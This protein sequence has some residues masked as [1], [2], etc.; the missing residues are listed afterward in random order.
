[1]FADVDSR[2]DRFISDVPLEVDEDWH[3]DEQLV[4]SVEGVPAADLLEQ[5]AREDHP[6]C[7]EEEGWTGLEQYP[8]DDA[9]PALPHSAP[10]LPAAEQTSPRMSIVACSRPVLF[11]KYIILVV[12]MLCLFC[13]CGR[14]A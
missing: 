1:M 8:P 13:A 14:W 2:A 12:L 10:H 11:P 4:D 9:P 7:G 5:L 6:Y 3:E